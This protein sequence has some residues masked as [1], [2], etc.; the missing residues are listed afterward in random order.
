MKCPFRKTMR[1]PEKEEMGWN[2]AFCRTL[3]ND[4][5]FGV[6][7]EVAT[8][9][10]MSFGSAKLC[11]VFSVHFGELTDATSTH[12]GLF[13]YWQVQTTIWHYKLEGGRDCIGVKPS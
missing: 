7:V 12:L 6:E 9:L 3:K 10:S 5:P 4:M 8:T 11:V 1:K 2:C 13:E